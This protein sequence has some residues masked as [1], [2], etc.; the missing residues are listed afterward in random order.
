MAA[1]AADVIVIGAGLA[2]LNAALNLEAAGLSVIVLEAADYVGGRTRT[3]DFPIGSINAGGQTIGPYYARLRDLVTKL[4]VPLI[5]APRGLAMG[6]YVNGSLMSSADWPTSKA[7]K[8]VG[9]ERKVQPQALEFFYMS[10][11]NNPLPDPESWSDAA[12]AQYDI[13]LLAY[14]RSKGASDEAIR[15][16]DVTVNAPD[17]SSASALAYLRDIKWLEW[18]MAQPDPNSQTTYGAGAGYHEV[19][20]G[21]QRLPEA[22]ARALKQEV[23]K[24]QLVRSIDVTDR[25]AEVTTHDGVRYQGKYVV[26]A[27]PFSALRYVDIRPN[28]AGQQLAAVQQ[29]THGNAIRVFMEFTAPFWEGDI[30]EP[31]LFSDTSIERVFANADE[32]GKPFALNCWLNGNGASR[33][34]QLPPEAI[35]EFVVEELARIRPSTRGR[36]KVL[37]VHSWA[38]HSASGCCR[39][40]YNAGQV[41]AW[42]EVMAKS[43]GRLHF[44]GEQTRSIE[45]GMEAAATT[46]ERAAYEIIEREN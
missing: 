6:N 32:A 28:L 17:L 5:P 20:G 44:A 42:S 14:L 4:A 12:Q 10:R 16:I 1:E 3:F 7:N 31:G 2:G 35:S 39:H 40:V 27:V 41:I 18:G 9:A 36:V 25:G 29:S 30:G 19:A 15:L 45:S 13:P 34:D 11:G 23:R 37:K 46:G 21:T 24:K 22:M 38:K 33:L 26:S 43:H 8:T